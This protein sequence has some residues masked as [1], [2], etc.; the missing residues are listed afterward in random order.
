MCASSA[1]TTAP[2]GPNMSISELRASS[3]MESCVTASS[4][5]SMVG[6]RPSSMKDV[7]SNVMINLKGIGEIYKIRIGHDNSGQDPGWYLEEVR[8]ENTATHELICFTVD[9]WIAENENDGDTWKEMPVMRTNNATLPVVVYEVHVYTG[10]RLGAETE[11]HVFIN[12]VGTRGDSGTRRLHRSTNNKVQFQRG[13]VDIF[14]I[15]AVSLGKLKKVLISH[16]GTGPGNGWFLE[17]LIVK[18]EEEDDSLLFPCN[19]WLDE[20]REDGRTERE[21]LP[22]GSHGA[23]ETGSVTS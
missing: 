12:L 19:R 11:A 7:G 17:R 2:A 16:D 15:K 8:L 18:S 21:L 10:S 6:H 23:G 9:S 3:E 5:F 1:L 14:S 22:E 13:Q 20:Y 4:V